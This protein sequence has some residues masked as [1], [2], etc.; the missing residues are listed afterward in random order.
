MTMKAVSPLRYPGGKFCLLE[1][2]ARILQHNDLDRAHYAEPFAGGGGLAL[3]LLYRG[4]VAHIHLN[5]IDPAIHAFWKCVLEHNGE[6]IDLIRHAPLTVDEW[7]RQ[8]EIFREGDAADT[9]G[10][11]FATFYLNRTNH[12]GVIKDAGVLGGLQQT[13]KNLIDCRFNKDDLADRLRRIARYRSQITLTGEDA[14]DFLARCN[15]LPTRSLVYA[16]PPYYKKGPGLYMSFYRHDD[17]LRLAT[18]I[19]RLK[20]PWMVTYDDVAAI[21][22]AYCRRK[23]YLFD[24]KY[25]LNDKR[26]GTEIMVLSDRLKAP[27]VIDTKRVSWRGAIPS[28]ASEVVECQ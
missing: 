21:R 23:I 18:A 25:T 13:G 16:D 15:S 1:A 17:H 8:R 26:K 12:S 27:D 9:L 19:Q 6:F 7:R 5:D 22:E 28:V 3:A 24:V 20:R 4:H 14:I 11:G 2:T 10:L